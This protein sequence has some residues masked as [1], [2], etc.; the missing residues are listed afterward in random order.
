MWPPHVMQFAKPGKTSQQRPFPLLLP[1]LLLA[2]LPQFIQARIQ[3]QGWDAC[4]FNH[5]DVGNLRKSSSSE[6]YDS[7]WSGS[8]LVQ[9]ISQGSLFGEAKLCLS[10][11]PKYLVNFSLFAIF[12]P[13]VK[14][15]ELPADL[16]R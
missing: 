13:V 3:K 14:V 8:Q 1:G 9:H 5:A 7:I 4:G 15:F 11:V 16:F 2:A 6:S 10:V 12:D